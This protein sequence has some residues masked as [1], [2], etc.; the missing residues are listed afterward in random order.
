MAIAQSTTKP[1]KESA[2][3]FQFRLRT[4]FIV[5]AALAVLLSAWKTLDLWVDYVEGPISSRGFSRIKIG[6][7]LD[8]VEAILGPGE[9]ISL[10]HVTQIPGSPY[11]KR[12]GNLD[13]VVEGDEF[14]RW[15]NSK[16]GMEIQLGLRDGRV[17]DKWYWEPSL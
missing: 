4:L 6:M 12:K 9:Q 7:S 17:C 14:F 3:P 11:A 16:C 5:T 10:E 1:K 8:E 13:L 15:H 2:R